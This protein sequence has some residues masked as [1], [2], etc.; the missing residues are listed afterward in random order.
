MSFLVPLDLLSVSTVEQ[1]I[2]RCL[3]RKPYLTAL[4]IANLT[5]IPLD[6]LEALLRQMV[7]DS[8]LAQQDKDGRHTFMVAFGRENGAKRERAGNNLL[9][10]LFH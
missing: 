4:E 2:I 5:K 6:E 3:I 7:G 8:H 9:G 10:A 1:D